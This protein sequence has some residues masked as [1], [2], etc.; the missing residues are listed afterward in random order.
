MGAGGARSLTERRRPATK[1]HPLTPSDS[2]PISSTLLPI[3]GTTPTTPSLSTLAAACVAAIGTH[4]DPA[5][6]SAAAHAAAALMA[7]CLCPCSACTGLDCPDCRGADGAA[8]A[9]A[10]ARLG[11]LAA[12]PGSGELRSPASDAALT[13][14]T[15]LGPHQAVGPGALAAVADI[16]R[17]ALGGEGTEEM[18]ADTPATPLNP[19]ALDAALPALTHLAACLPCW[20]AAGDGGGPLVEAGVRSTLAAFRAGE[21]ARLAASRPPA[22]SAL[23]AAAEAVLA[24]LQAAAGGE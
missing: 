12:A 16:A 22:A 23:R 24:G 13:I 3:P 5:R 2:L 7:S 10:G 14:L 8:A 19:A 1:S 17:A 6:A 18:G 9:E 11:A 15:H 20:L 4:I 21:R